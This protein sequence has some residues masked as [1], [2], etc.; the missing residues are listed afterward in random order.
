[1]TNNVYLG[2]HLLVK[3]W[4][5]ENNSKLLIVTVIVVTVSKL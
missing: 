1:M 3:Q 5:K 2:I 4:Y